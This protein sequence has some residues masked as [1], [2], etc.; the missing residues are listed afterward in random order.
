MKIA[1]VGIGGSG[2]AALRFLAQAGHEAI[3]FEQ[4]N[5]GH[6]Y[7]SS[8]GESR[9][10]RFVYPDAF[11]TGLMK[12]AYPL[13]ESLE[14]QAQEELFVRC[15]MTFFGPD[16]HPHMRATEASLLQ[17]N[18]SFDKL[19][20]TVAQNR[21]PGLRFHSGEVVIFQKEG[22]FL[23]ANACLLSN[24][25][26]A[27]KYGAQLHQNTAV[28]AIFQ[29]KNEVVLQTDDNEFVFDRVIVTAGAWMG[30]L[31][32]SLN[33]PLRVTRQ[34]I[35]YL[36]ARHP[37]LFDAANFP[38][39]IDAASLYY[40]FPMDGRINGVKFASHHVGETVQPDEVARVVD[41]NYV[42]QAIDY[43]AKRLPDLQN[44]VTYSAVCLY[45]NTP[46]EDFILDKVPTMPNVWMVSGCSGHGFKFTVL[47]GYIAATLASGGTYQRDIS[48]FSLE[49]FGIS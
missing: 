10:I 38:V 32:S 29:H 46:N 6:S 41:E 47:L 2:S 11:Y 45:T 33:L 3:G 1:V 7:G 26:L 44:E 37:Q 12:D 34:Q 17:N 42:Q 5:I 43:A 9:I 4:F 21:V 22:G 40:G 24:V 14:E 36:S 16:D 18:L 48:R 27:Q 20:G 35:V 15:G 23:R 19:S 39:W 49:K 13:W 28:R 25:R 8:H 31:L 30:Q